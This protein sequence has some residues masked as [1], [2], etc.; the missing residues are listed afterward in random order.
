MPGNNSFR[1]EFWDQFEDS[2][3]TPFLADKMKQLIELHRMAVP[4]LQDL[5]VKLWP[6]GA[7]PT[8]YFGL[9]R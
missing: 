2:N 7:L 5:S 8:S 1:K 9:L 3:R 6:T 4:A